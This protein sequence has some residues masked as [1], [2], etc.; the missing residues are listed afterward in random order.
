MRNLVVAIGC[1]S[2]AACGYVGDP[3][4]PALNIPVPPTNFQAIQRGDK[5]LITFEQSS[6]TTD[7]LKLH[8]LGEPQIE[9]A[10][11]SFE[12]SQTTDG[13]VRFETPVMPFIGK[14]VSVR[15]R[16]NNGRGRYSQWSGVQNVTVVAPLSPPRDVEVSSVPEGVRVS[17]TAEQRPEK[18]SYRVLRTAK[19]N[20]EVMIAQGSPFIDTT[21]QVGEDY[22]YRVQAIL[23]SAESA[24]TPPVSLAHADKAPPS[25]PTGLSVTFGINAAELTWE[26]SPDSDVAGYRVYRAVGAGPMQVLADNVSVPA[27]TDT[28]VQPKTEYRYVVTAL[29][30]SGNE[31][32]RSTEARITVP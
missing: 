14:E 27:H 6:L 12:S 28:T 23:G 21:A 24:P 13:V 32:A 30:K 4:P 7:G 18:L 22:N 15:V 31:S 29:D 2:L 1:L 9:I 19:G 10:G 25:A 16:V 11:E 3:L 26:R 5:L 17:W 20:T 8:H